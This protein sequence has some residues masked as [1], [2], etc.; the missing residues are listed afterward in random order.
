MAQKRIVFYEDD[1]TGEPSDDTSTHRLL[2][3]G[4]GVELDLTPVSHDRLMD[5][6]RPFLSAK[7]ARRIRER[8]DSSP[9]KETSQQEEAKKIRAWAH[10]NGIQVNLRGRVSQEVKAAYKKANS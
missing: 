4:A 9:S 5:A 1:L 6:L 8:R 3:D 7:G 2:L 10:A